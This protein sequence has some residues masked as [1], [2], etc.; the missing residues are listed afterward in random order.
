MVLNLS[1]SFSVSTEIMFS[2]LW[3]IDKIG[4]LMLNHP[5]ISWGKQSLFVM[6]YVLNT[7]LNWLA[8]ILLGIMVVEVPGGFFLC[9]QMVVTIGLFSVVVEFLQRKILHIRVST[10]GTE[11]ER[12]PG[13]PWSGLDP[14][15]TACLC[16]GTSLPPPCLGAWPARELLPLS[17]PS[18]NTSQLLQGRERVTSWRRYKWFLVQ[19]SR[20][21]P[22]LRG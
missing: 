17:F 2:L 3:S 21:S 15:L 14:C 7:L 1:N 19:A 10:P 18:A 22:C 16:G 8:G 20:L 13:A 9:D 5:C 4:L 6:C 12:K 11:Q